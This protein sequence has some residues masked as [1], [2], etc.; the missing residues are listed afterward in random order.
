MV[1]SPFNE[2]IVAIANL[3]VETHSQPI[4]TSADKTSQLQ[5]TSEDFGKFCLACQSEYRNLVTEAVTS[6][7]PP[8]QSRFFFVG[9]LSF[10]LVGN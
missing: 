3:P 5:F 2:N 4:E 1:P 8:K 6:I 9:P 7:L 10:S